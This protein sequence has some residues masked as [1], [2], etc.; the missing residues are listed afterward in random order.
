MSAGYK[1]SEEDSGDEVCPAVLFLC[2]SLFVSYCY[3]CVWVGCGVVVCVLFL[4]LFFFILNFKKCVFKDDKG[5]KKPTGK[6]R[7]NAGNGANLATYSWTQ[8]LQEVE[9]RSSRCNNNN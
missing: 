9:V 5:G 3:D 7:P 1:L 6:L 4:L 8:T 2:R